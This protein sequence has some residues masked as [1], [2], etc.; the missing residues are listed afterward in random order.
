[1]TVVAAVPPLARALARHPLVDRYD[2]SSLRLVLIG[3]APCPA[4]IERE[5][6]EARLG[7]VVGQSFG[8]TEVAPI[9]LPEEPACPGSLGRLVP[10]IE[11]VVVDPDS[12]DGWG[13]GRPGEL[14]LR[15]PAA[16]GAA[17]S[18]TRRRRGDDRRPGVAALRRSRALRRGR[19]PVR[20]RSPQGAHQGAAATRWRRR[21]SRPSSTLHPAVA[22]VAVVPRPDEEAGERAGGLR[23]AV[24]AAPSRAP[25]PH[26]WPSAWRP[27]SGSAEVVVVDEIPRNPTGKLLRRVLVERERAAARRPT[28]IGRRC[29]RCGRPR[30][31]P[32]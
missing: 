30:L 1:M 29:D 8:M 10:G 16:H 13:R 26:G 17:T 31:T 32:R 15:G 6:C 12:G 21:S 23:H 24:R 20:R 14:W 27:T 11:A 4:E 3:A 5:C 2:L 7:C 18:A 19:P 25:S 22:D 9:A 28:R